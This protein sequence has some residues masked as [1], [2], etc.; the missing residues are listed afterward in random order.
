MIFKVDG[1]LIYYMVVVVDDYLMGIDIVVCGEEWILLMF[2][3]LLFYKWLGWEV[4][5]FVYMFLLCNID[6]FK[7]FKCK[8]LVVWLMWFCE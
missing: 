8:N 7:I 1:F 2:K 6:K 5:K 3:Y 4:L